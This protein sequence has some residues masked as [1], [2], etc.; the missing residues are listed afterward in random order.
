MKQGGREV[1]RGEHVYDCTATSL[2]GH[3]FLNNGVTIKII[4]GYSLQ[5]VGHVNSI[6]KVLR[7][8]KQRSEANQI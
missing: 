7:C 4:Y 2:Y 1:I 6:S 8:H 3:V 5:F